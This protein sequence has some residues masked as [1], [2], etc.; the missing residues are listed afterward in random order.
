MFILDYSNYNLYFEDYIKEK[1]LNFK[2]QKEADAYYTIWI[3]GFTY[4]A[5]V[6]Y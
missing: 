5:Q 6:Y 2:S 4:A 3:E 1:H